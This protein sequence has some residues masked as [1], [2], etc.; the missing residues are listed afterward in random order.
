M[1]S[2]RQ[3]KSQLR[4]ARCRCQNKSSRH[5]V[6]RSSLAL[7]RKTLYI[8]LHEGYR[9]A[10]TSQAR[11]AVRA[12][13]KIYSLGDL[14]LGQPTLPDAPYLP[15]PPFPTRS[16]PTLPSLPY[17]PGGRQLLRQQVHFA[18]RLH[19]VFRLKVRQEPELFTAQNVICGK[20]V[21]RRPAGCSPRT[22]VAPWVCRATCSLVHD[23]SPL[24]HLYHGFGQ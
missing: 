6:Q 20:V 1:R 22:G 3:R 2:R 15:P 9:I 23:P 18:A 11:E 24:P 13:C 4:V 16:Y 17:P 14:Y 7:L 12:W 5:R 21:T 19:E 10:I 8:D